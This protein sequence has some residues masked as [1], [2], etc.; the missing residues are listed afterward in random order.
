MDGCRRCEGG[1]A[2]A[3]PLELEDEEDK[4]ED[5]PVGVLVLGRFGSVGDAVRGTA[6]TITGEATRGASAMIWGLALVVEA[7]AR[8]CA[9][10]WAA[11][12]VAD[13]EVDCSA[14]SGPASEY[15]DAMLSIVEADVA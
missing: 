2:A 11:D 13:R 10:S 14:A 8:A 12:G 3:A 5:A 9:F 6:A 7:S 1:A 4:E 15:S